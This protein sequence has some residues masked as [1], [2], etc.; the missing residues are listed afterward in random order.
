MNDNRDNIIRA[1]PVFDKSDP[2]IKKFY[3]DL[4]IALDAVPGGES[5]MKIIG[6]L[7][8]FKADL[9]RKYQDQ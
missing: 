5:I 7:E 2:V 9:I 1:E 8:V 3:N 4:D 6:C